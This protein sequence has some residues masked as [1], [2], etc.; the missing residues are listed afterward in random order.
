MKT[1]VMDVRIKASQRYNPLCLCRYLQAVESGAVIVDRTQAIQTKD[2]LRL[3]D[4]ILNR[5]YLWNYNNP[6]DVT[7]YLEVCDGDIY[8]GVYDMRTG[9]HITR[10]KIA[11][12]HWSLYCGYYRGY[13]YPVE[14]MEQ[15][16][17]AIR[18]Y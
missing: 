10:T 16:R 8:G 18:Q 15:I 1:T 11:S 14:V 17:E 13:T 9:E 3:F 7:I 6:D 2:D 12:E 5:D 4:V